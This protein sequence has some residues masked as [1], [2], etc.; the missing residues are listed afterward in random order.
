MVNYFKWPFDVSAGKYRVQYQLND[1]GTLISSDV[2]TIAAPAPVTF[3]GYAYPFSCGDSSQGDV[4]DGRIRL[5]GYGGTGTY[6]YRINSGNWTNFP[7]NSMLLYL[8]AGTYDVEIRDSNQCIGTPRYSY[9]STLTIEQPDPITILEEDIGMVTSYGNNNGYINTKITGGRFPGGNLRRFFRWERD[10]GGSIPEPTITK[11]GDEININLS[12]LVAGTYT[13]YV[14]DRNDCS[15]Q[16][17]F[18]VTQPDPLVFDQP[19]TITHI[20]CYG[21][22]NG[23]ISITASGGIPN[24]RFELLKRDELG[25]FRATGDQLYTDN[26]TTAIFT[27]NNLASGTY[28]IVLT[29]NL[30]NG[31]QNN[32]IFS[33]IYTINEAAPI[34]YTITSTTDVSCHGGNDGTARVT[35]SG[36]SGNYLFAWRKNGEDVYST[37]QNPN[38]LEAG[39]YTLTVMDENVEGCTAINPVTESEIVINEPEEALTISLID[40]NAPT[41][42]TNNGNLHIQGQGGTPPYTYAWNTGQTTTQINNL[43]AGTYI[44]TLTDAKGCSTNRSFILDELAVTIAVVP[45]EEITCN[46]GRTTLFATATGGDNQYTYAWFN[47]N[48]PST[49]SYTHLTLPTTSRV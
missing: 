24:Y 41:G 9:M 37:T 18:V 34:E 31:T 17:D 30:Q 2:F 3:T 21:S 13:L 39:I 1:Y 26:L 7:S 28:R 27:V 46:G 40:A 20:D 11:E 19:A 14:T 49:V 36:G 15:T 33:S 10:S 45:G 44:V 47:Q 16:R 22:E 12:G 8:A 35:V 38:N 32:L 43:S 23:S 42:G 4:S 48:N 29:D 25:T 5:Q 6:Q